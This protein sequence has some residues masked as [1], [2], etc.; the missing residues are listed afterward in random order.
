MM[1]T[2]F[3]A[4]LLHL[5]HMRIVPHGVE[6][7]GS[8][9]RAAHP[10]RPPMI[11]FQGRLVNTKGVHVLLEA[12]GTLRSQNRSFELIIIGDG[13]ERSKL[14]ELAQKM[15]L[16]ACTRFM[17]HLDAREVESILA[18][19]TVVAVP[20]LAGEVFGLVVAENMSRGLP[21]VA[22]NLGAFKEILGEAGVTFAVGDANDL[23][24]QLARLL[25]DSARA[26][27][28]GG[29]AKQRV[30]EVYSRKRMIEVHAQLFREV[31]DPQ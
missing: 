17:G 27:R 3:L 26:S 1:P 15:G 18:N 2:E 25:D 4:G 16:S 28:L 21:V 19:A 9:H 23:A 29:W 11:A 30:M 14:Q 6:Q 5:A 12:A 10:L 24:R 31:Y 13:P 20:S 7:S 22:S 8:F